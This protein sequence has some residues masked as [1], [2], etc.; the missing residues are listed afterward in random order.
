MGQLPDFH[1]FFRSR[2]LYRRPSKSAAMEGAEIIRIHT[3][4]DIS[5]LY[6]SHF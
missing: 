3:H 6:S 5:C 2:G 4:A 1:A